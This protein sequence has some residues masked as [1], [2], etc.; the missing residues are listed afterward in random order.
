MKECRQRILPILNRCVVFNTTSNSYHGHPDPL[1]CPEGIT[2][3]SIAL[4]Y[5]TN[6][7]DD[8]F[9]SEREHS[10]LWQARPGKKEAYGEGPAVWSS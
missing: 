6:G 5:Y 2:R 1:T 10:T 3:N 7:R 4:Y 9:E 8:G